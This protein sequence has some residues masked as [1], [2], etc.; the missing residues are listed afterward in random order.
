MIMF[1]SELHRLQQIFKQLPP[2]H[3]QMLLVFAEFLQTRVVSNSASPLQPK[4]IPRPPQESVIAAIKRLSQ[5]YP[6]LEKS[7]MLDKTSNLMTEHILHG[8]DKV[9]VIDELEMIF[10]QHYEE[11]LREQTI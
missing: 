1:N 10:E 7:K 5:S 9:A 4:Y 2:E 11:Y 6:M 8:R 3:Q